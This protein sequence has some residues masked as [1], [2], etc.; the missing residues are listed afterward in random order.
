MGKGGGEEEDYRPNNSKKRV[1]TMDINEHYDYLIVGGGLYGSL[2]AYLAKKYENKTSLIVEKRPF[3]GGNLHCE[4]KC[5]INV[6][7][8]G[9][10][11]F[12]TNNKKVWTF[13]NSITR[14]NSFINQPVAVYGD[15]VYHLPFNMNT[16]YELWGTRLPE[17]AEIKLLEQTAA[18][19]EALNGREP[20]NLE[21]QA[22]S[23]V[24][25]D[26]YETLIKGYTEKQWGRP[27]NQLPS[28]II[29]RLPVRFTYNN[30]Y[31]NDTYQGIPAGGTYNNFID[32][33]LSDCDVLLNTDFFEH[34]EE[35][36]QCA[37]KVVYT[38]PLD[39]L[40]DYSEGEL[41]WRSL[42]FIETEGYSPIYMGNAV[43]NF[44][45]SEVAY[46][47]IIEH[48]FFDTEQ[49]PMANEKTIITHE[50]PQEYKKG[51]EPYYPINDE[52]NNA[53]AEKYKK[54]LEGQDK[55]QI[56]GRLAE[57]KYYDMSVIV[58][59]LLKKFH[60]IS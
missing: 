49:D 55:I 5:G 24:G 35:L 32:V 58:E 23:L 56:G 13:V 41:D 38:G 10:H 36:E 25:K 43:T 31:F 50:F 42:K 22:L 59:N 14:F 11:I 8:Y 15:K 45:S 54:M 33:L 52:R 37:D 39:R 51:C 20:Q 46:T 7:S 60:V 53:I 19:R 27:C 48:K 29:K 6:H 26:I 34:R 40:F 21:E 9:A 16:F 17:D 57:Y 28:S 30:N 18:A 4:N 1:K 3:V 47:R 2:F 44:T 12:H